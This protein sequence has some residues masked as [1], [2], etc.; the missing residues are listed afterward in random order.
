M[1]PPLRAASYDL[2]LRGASRAFVCGDASP[3][4][5]D[6]VRRNRLNAANCVLYSPRRLFLRRDVV[7]FPMTSGE[8]IGQPNRAV[9]RLVYTAAAIFAVSLPGNTLAGQRLELGLTGGLLTWKGGF[10]EGVPGLEMR[11]VISKE[12]GSHFALTLGAHFN[13]HIGL[14]FFFAGG[15][16]NYDAYLYK[17]PFN[18]DD[19]MSQTDCNEI[20]M[21]R[22]DVTIHPFKTRFSPYVAGGA[23][24][25]K[26]ALGGDLLF[27]LGGGIKWFFAH[28]LALR[29]DYRRMFSPLRDELLVYDTSP[30]R[31]SDW[32]WV[33][34][35]FKDEI[36]FH[37]FTIG[38]MWYVVR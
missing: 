5:N 7:R 35:P 21:A 25:I 11:S 27:G 36:T 34:V 20:F 28:R 23:G 1:S 16:W 9:R 15:P 32:R 6:F 18:P 37:Q 24:Y 29:A 17:P 33:G 10:F 38:I 2:S 4:F 13:E 3:L 22:G 14:D 30:P 26:T 12:R 31:P 8:M 19:A